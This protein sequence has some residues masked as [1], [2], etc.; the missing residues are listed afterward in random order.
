MVTS[1][2]V[3][4]L[5][6]GI[7]WWFFGKQRP[8][9]Q[10]QQEDIPQRRREDPL[11]RATRMLSPRSR[12]A[13]VYA[14]DRLSGYPLRAAYRGKNG[15]LHNAAIVRVDCQNN[16]VFLRHKRGPIFERPLVGDSWTPPGNLQR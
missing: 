1:F 4:V 15:K 14:W 11:S 5:F 12:C 13:A 9:P 3:G 2:V 16:T 7:L 8:L 10:L 6:V